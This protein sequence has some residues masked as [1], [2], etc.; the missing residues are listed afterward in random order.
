MRCGLVVEHYAA[1][2]LLWKDGSSMSLWGVQLVI[3]KLVTDEEF[4]LRFETRAHESLAKLCEQGIDLNDIEVAAFLETDPQLWSAMAK[5]VDRRLRPNR[6]SRLAR[7]TEARPHRAFTERERYVLRGI[8][9]GRTNKRIAADIGVSEGA[10]KAT[11]QHLFRKTQVRTRAQ[12]VRMV[13]E[14]SL[15]PAQTSR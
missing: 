10:V 6:A 4:R 12:L 5:Q 14:G 9:E 2:A 8:F 11:L 3:G 15:G 13:I 7:T 1:N